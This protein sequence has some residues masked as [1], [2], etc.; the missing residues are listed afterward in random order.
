M[1]ASR[2][3]HCFDLFYRPVGADKPTE[4]SF[5]YVALIVLQ[6]PKEGYKCFEAKVEGRVAENIR[7]KISCSRV[8]HPN[9]LDNDD[10]QW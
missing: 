9:E 7:D 4:N 10:C 6:S 2:S 1:A 5:Q 3:Q 8:W